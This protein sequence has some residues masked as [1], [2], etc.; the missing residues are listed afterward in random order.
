MLVR[1][2]ILALPVLHACTPGEQAQEV[3]SPPAAPAPAP[4]AVTAEQFQTLRWLGGTWRGT[5]EGVSP[6]F[7]R[8]RFVDDSTIRRYS[9]SDSSFAEISDS[10]TT[11]LRGASVTGGDPEPEWL[12]TSVDSVGW[13]FESLREAGRGFTW[14]RTSDD[15]WTA[16][17]V[18]RDPENNARERVYTLTRLTR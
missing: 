16:R 7:E 8:Y 17:L 6:F 18:W 15:L 5:G 11:A 3:A 12:V 1:F 14:S 9:Y 2:L 10:G 4:A 13:R